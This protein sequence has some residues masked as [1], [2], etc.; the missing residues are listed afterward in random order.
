MS[1][2]A[3]QQTPQHTAQSGLSQSRLESL[4]ESAKLLS[5]HLNLDQLLGHLLRTAMGAS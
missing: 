4:L 2:S 5:S 3:T 1:S